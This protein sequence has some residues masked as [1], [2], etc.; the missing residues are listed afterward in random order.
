MSEQIY[1]ALGSVL[2]DCVPI[3]KDRRNKMQGFQFRGIDDAYNALHPIMAKHQICTMPRVLNIEREERQT[4]AGGT[5]IYTMLTV[6][7]DFVSGED[8][9][10][11]TVGPVIG[12]AMDSGDKSCNKAL[13]MAH[14][15]V[16]FQTFM[17]P[18][19][20]EDADAASHD[21]AFDEATDKQLAKIKDYKEA[22]QI[23]EATQAWID[24]QRPLT[25]KKAAGLLRR[26]KE[27]NK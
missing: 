14:K 22:D 5:L 8:G 24:K 1:T 3:A 26:L 2:K 4:K 17:I 6:E 10:K 18:T 21:L 16:L 15:Y 11:V 20:M 13:A 9:S 25:E 7:Y 19:H 27:E 12:E 23:H